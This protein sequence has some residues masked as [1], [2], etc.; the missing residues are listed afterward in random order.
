M[1]KNIVKE[2]GMT[3]THLKKITDTSTSSLNPGSMNTYLASIIDSAN[4]GIYVTDRDRCFLLWNETAEKISGYNKQEIIGR[5][6]NDNILC[7]VDRNGNELCSSC[8]PLK[9]AIENGE[10]QGPEIVFLKHKNGKR[11]AVEVRTAAIRGDQGDI[12]G[13]VE[14]FQDV[15]ER[16]DQEHLLRERKEKLETVLDHIGDGILFLD[17]KGT[18][19]VFNKACRQMFDLERN[20]LGI[21]IHSISDKTP[22]NEILNGL[23][24][25]YKR[26]VTSSEV[27]A[28]AHPACAEGRGLF[29]CWTEGIDRSPM[30]P[31]SPCFT[32]ETFHTVKAF[33]EKP[34]EMAWDERTLSV[35]SSFIELPDVNEL[36]EVIAFHDV[37]MEKLDAALKVSGAVAH[38]LR[39]PLQAIVILAGLLER[40]WQNQKSLGKYAESI[41]SSCDRMDR[42][43]QRMTEITRYRTKDYIDGRK[44]LDFENSSRKT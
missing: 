30:A 21:T 17:T 29:R 26:M 8:C 27:N 39:Q 23:E 15:T 12:V 28:S 2:S 35:V 6:C 25:L 14:V 37:T 16:L 19:T 42:I 1:Q 20:S 7:H 41:L 44:I 40:R 10:P 36:W 33:L 3:D 22:L 4:D 34:C 9:A 24:V 38:E 13:A 18:I 5:R 32:C 31:R 43:I 11:L